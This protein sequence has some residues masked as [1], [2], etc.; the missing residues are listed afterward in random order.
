VTATAIGMGAA[1]EGELVAFRHVYVEHQPRLQRLAYAV[2]LD[3]D[4]AADVVQEAFLKLHREGTVPNVEAWLMK[5]TLRSAL[6]W[7]RR[8][9]RFRRPAP[10][11][12][13]TAVTP[14]RDAAARQGLL[15]MQGAL[16]KL[17]ALQRAV[18]ALNVDRGLEP[19][20]VAAALGISANHARV[21][22]HRA[23][24]AVRA[25]GVPE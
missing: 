16:E 23:L 7:R 5:V 14:E 24:K 19:S 10:L 21:T 8:L 25:A 3:R 17:P 20:D 12:T 6:S 22:L 1:S 11:E 2:V 18:L 4:E 9:L 13:T 15:V